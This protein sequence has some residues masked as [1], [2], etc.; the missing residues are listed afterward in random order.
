MLPKSNLFR[1]LC[2]SGLFHIVFTQNL[3]VNP[4]SV[5]YDAGQNRYLVSN[6][7]NGRVVQIDAEGNQSYFNQELGDTHNLVGLHITAGRLLASANN[8]PLEGVISFDLESGELMDHYAIPGHD[9]LN[10]ITSDGTGYFYVSDYYASRI[11]KVHIATGDVTMLAYQNLDYPNGIFFDPFRQRLLALSVGGTNGPVLEVDRETGDIDIAGYTGL[12]GGDGL[13][14]DSNGNFYISDWTSN[15]VHRFDCEFSG[16]AEI[17]SSGHNA[18]ADIF[19]RLDANILC[20]PNFYE[21]MVEFIPVD[22]G[23]PCCFEGDINQDGIINVLDVIQLLNCILYGSECICADMDGN[24]ILNVLD[25]VTIVNIIM[26][27]T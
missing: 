25:I 20:V 1:L 15:A 5:E 10:D 27:R 11:Y 7:G 22:P 23:E 2:L 24:G 16:G 14:M 9:M 17:V 6:F 19:Y 12:N 3:L 8:G 18:P 26:S 21:N 4:E 13:T